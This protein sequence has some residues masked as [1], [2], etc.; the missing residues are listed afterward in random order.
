MINPKLVKSN[1]RNALETSGFFSAEAAIHTTAMVSE[2]RINGKK[3]KKKRLRI[4]ASLF[5]GRNK[6]AVTVSQTFLAFDHLDNFEDCGYFVECP[7]TGIF[8][9]FSY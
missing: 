8:L 5:L 6:M 2:V 4:L 3:R 7:S 9:K 1:N